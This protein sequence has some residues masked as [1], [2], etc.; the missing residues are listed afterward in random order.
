MLG[1]KKNREISRYAGVS[2]LT[3]FVIS[4]S[5]IVFLWSGEQSYKVSFALS[6]NFLINCCRAMGNIGANSLT[7]CCLLFSEIYSLKLIYIAYLR[8]YTSFNESISYT[9]LFQ[10]YICKLPRNI[11]IREN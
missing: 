8:V 7:I 9:K 3:A 2:D 11:H 10:M 1:D 6:M 4:N 5:E